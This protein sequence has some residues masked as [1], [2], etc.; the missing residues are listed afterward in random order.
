MSW[1]RFWNNWLC[2]DRHW[3]GQE[4]NP[5]PPEYSPEVLLLDPGRS[6][7]LFCFFYIY[8][9]NCEK[10]PLFR[11]SRFRGTQIPLY[12]ARISAAVTVSGG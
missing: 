10:V 5:V 1:K 3:P 6:V 7:G 8:K 12:H 9:A 4:S 11:G 2:R